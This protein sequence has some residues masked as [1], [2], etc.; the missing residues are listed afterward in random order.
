MTR[1]LTLPGSRRALDI[2][3]GVLAIV[4]LAALALTV[5][6]PNVFALERLL[7]SLVNLEANVQEGLIHP[8]AQEMHV[9][10]LRN[11]MLTAQLIVIAAGLYYGPIAVAQIV[12]TKQ[13]FDVAI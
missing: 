6:A 12:L 10:L 7:D 1:L 4:L 8:T 3:V 11:E 5:W 9:V 2:A 13:S